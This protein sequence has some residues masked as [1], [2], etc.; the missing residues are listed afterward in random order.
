IWQQNLNNSRTAQESLLNGPT[1]LRWD[2]LTLQE[3]C[4]N[5]L[6]NT[7]STRKWHTVYP[8]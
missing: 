5:K 6:C 1:A 4:S 3:C 2:I 7:R 8:T